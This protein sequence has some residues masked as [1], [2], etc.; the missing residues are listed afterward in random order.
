MT[1]SQEHIETVARALANDIHQGGDF[2]MTGSSAYKA[3]PKEFRKM[4]LAAIQA[5]EEVREKEVTDWRGLLN[6]VLEDTAKELGC[7]PDNE[8]ILQ[9]IYD[10]KK[11]AQPTSG[12]EPVNWTN[13]RLRSLI[14]VVATYCYEEPTF[15]DYAL[16]DKLIND[17]LS[18][19]KP[20]GGE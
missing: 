17:T 7:D 5:Y 11:R 2:G 8:A 18:H 3:R 1:P 10:L 15:F 13:R 14:D 12:D 16:S 19:P 9:A 6:S 4:A 20:N